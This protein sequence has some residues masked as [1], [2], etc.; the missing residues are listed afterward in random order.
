[1]RIPISAS[2]GISTNVSPSSSDQGHGKANARVA[3][4]TANVQLCERS[5]GDC[6]GGRA[7]LRITGATSSTPTASPRYQRPSVGQIDVSPSNHGQT[8]P[9]TAP[10]SGPTNA[11]ATRNTQRSRRREMSGTPSSRHLTTTAAT[12]GTT[13]CAAPNPIDTP[14]LV[15][16]ITFITASATRIATVY[17]GHSRDGRKTNIATLTPAAGQNTTAPAESPNVVSR[18]SSFHRPA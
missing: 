18:P 9:T 3:A 5:N 13:A 6:A 12:S 11:A 10:T 16:S 2:T 8:D 15:P 1:M 7:M 14:A 4:R 17:A